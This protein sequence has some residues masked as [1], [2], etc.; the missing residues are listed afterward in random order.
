M[1]TIIASTVLFPSFQ[2]ASFY[3]AATQEASSFNKVIL[4][5]TF[6]L[7]ILLFMS[8]SISL[9]EHILVTG[10]LSNE[11]YESIQIL[12]VIFWT[13]F[14]MYNCQNSFTDFFGLAENQNL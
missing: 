8:F 10:N 2:Y 11:Q 9:K 3:L 7:P 6:F 4:H 14:A 12:G 13:V 1:F 5:G